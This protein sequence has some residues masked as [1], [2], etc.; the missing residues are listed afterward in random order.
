MNSL[1]HH[2]AAEHFT[3]PEVWN[4]DKSHCVLGTLPKGARLH[5]QSPNK[6]LRGSF[7]E[8]FCDHWELP[9]TPTQWSLVNSRHRVLRGMHFHLRHDE[10]ISVI[11]GRAI[12]GLYDLRLD[13]LS[14]GTSA[15]ILLTE[16]DPTC[17]VFPAG[18]VHGW[19]FLEETTHLQAVSES[20]KYYGATDNHG[21]IW[22]DPDLGLDWPDQNPILAERAAGFGSLGELL[23]LVKKAP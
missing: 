6:D 20:Y 23:E 16:Q 22:S 1:S 21:C 10:Y 11:R 15:M 8:V 3:L 17:L 13:S 9:V 19:Y 7:T 2:P 12:I 18:I 4:S 14:F 5:R